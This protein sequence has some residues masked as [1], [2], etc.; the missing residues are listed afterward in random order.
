MR[1]AAQI[2]QIGKTKPNE[3]MWPLRDFVKRRSDRE[4]QWLEA[5]GG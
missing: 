5:M 2:F 4:Y 1:A 3:S